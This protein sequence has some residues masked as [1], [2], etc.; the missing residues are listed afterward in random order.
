V[1][2]PTA[3]KSYGTTTG[4]DCMLIEESVC[5][6][7]RPYVQE[8]ANGGARISFSAHQSQHAKIFQWS[9]NADGLDATLINGDKSSASL[10]LSPPD[11]CA[12]SFTVTLTIEGYDGETK[13]CDATVTVS[14]TTAPTL[15]GLYAEDATVR[16]AICVCM[17]SVCVVFSL[18]TYFNHV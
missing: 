17:Y 8:C 7:G 9:H 2:F 13:S 14:D 1:F 10:R 3:R 5:D 11:L 18:Y 15:Y 16:L 12:A 4:P 6:D